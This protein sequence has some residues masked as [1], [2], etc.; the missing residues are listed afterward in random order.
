MLARPWRLPESPMD[1]R[2]GVPE[3][4]N[5]AVSKTV[6]LATV[7]RVRIPLPPPG[8]GAARRRKRA[9]WGSNPLPS[10]ARMLHKT[11]AQN[12][13]GLVQDEFMF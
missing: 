10:S 7:P 3:W 1:P 11:V 2:G 9:F 8:L 12:E 13:T 6:V 4:L 5:G